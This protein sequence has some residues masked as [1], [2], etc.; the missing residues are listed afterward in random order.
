MLR[1]NNSIK[2]LWIFRTSPSI[3]WFRHPFWLSEG[4]FIWNLKSLLESQWALSGGILLFT[5]YKDDSRKHYY[6]K[7]RLRLSWELYSLKKNYQSRWWNRGKNGRLSPNHSCLFWGCLLWK[8]SDAWNRKQAGS[9]SSWLASSSCWI[10]EK[11]PCTWYSHRWLPRDSRRY[12]RQSKSLK[13][14]CRNNRNY[15]GYLSASHRKWKWPNI[16]RGNA[17]G[18]SMSWQW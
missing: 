10:F 15:M 6:C 12:R 16:Y 8:K 17:W 7:D 1:G 2:T 14:I 3:I 18:W 5:L 11:I 13:N 4:S 9:C